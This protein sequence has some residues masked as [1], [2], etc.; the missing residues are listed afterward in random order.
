M[1]D[2]WYEVFEQATGETILRTRNEVLARF[3]ANVN[4]R[5]DYSPAGDER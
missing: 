2:V 1:Y 3:V 5:L 4:R